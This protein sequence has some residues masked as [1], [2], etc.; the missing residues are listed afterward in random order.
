MRGSSGR[1]ALHADG[2]CM[3]R[4]EGTAIELVKA[5]KRVMVAA[6]ECKRSQN[7]MRFGHDS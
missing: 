3:R 7:S 1:C 2:V 6:L 4:Y 5:V